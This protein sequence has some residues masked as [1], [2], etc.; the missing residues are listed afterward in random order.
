[1]LP[2]VSLFGLCNSII[3]C[4]VLSNKRLKGAMFQHMLLD[5][6]FSCVYSLSNSVTFIIRCGVYCPFGYAYY[7]KYYEIYFFIFIA[8]STE[9]F[10]LLLDINLSLIRLGSFSNK[11]N[12]QKI[13]D[14]ALKIRFACFFIIAF[15]TCVPVCILP[16]TISLI[17]Y[18]V[19]NQTMLNGTVVNQTEKALYVVGK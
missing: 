6:I 5:S 2:I 10:I 13:S 7:S 19:S 1:M 14:S 17:G 4:I 9:L 18:L 15:V 3:S 11:R 16:R 8:K 12:D